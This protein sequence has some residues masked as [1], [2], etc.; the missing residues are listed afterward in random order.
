MEAAVVVLVLVNTVLL[1]WLTLRRTPGAS[2]AEAEVTSG[3]EL[4]APAPAG[5]RPGGSDVLGGIQAA[6][7]FPLATL[8][9][10]SGIAQ[11]MPVPAAT[12]VR[13]LGS[14]SEAS[15]H[16]LVAA[17]A[18][19]ALGSGDLYRMVTRPTGEFLRKPDETF[20]AIG[21]VN[22]KISGH[23]DWAEVS[24]RS[25]QA[26]SALGSLA[27]IAAGAYWQQQVDQK[28]GRLQE[29]L[30][31][32]ASRLNTTLLAELAVSHD[33]LS[34]DETADIEGPYRPSAAVTDGL[35]AARID[36]IELR[37][38]FEKRV[39][40]QDAL[41][42]RDYV[43]RILRTA[44]D[45]NVTDKFQRAAF[46]VTLE[47][48]VLKLKWSHSYGQPPAY[49]EQLATELDDLLGRVDALVGVGR[50]IRSIE[51]RHPAEW[52]RV[53][54]SRRKLDQAAVQAKDGRHAIGD[55][56]SVLSDRLEEVY[57]LRRPAPDETVEVLLGFDGQ[58]MLVMAPS[59]PD[60]DS[61]RSP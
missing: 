27:T 28:L 23:A 22:G 42:H 8:E 3:T 25:V 29:G 50:E 37:Q 2:T 56:V 44:Q 46:G 12:G 9:E 7:R 45:E 58:R 18:L 43:E 52:K 15:S 34:L 60:S 21:R 39:A 26:A 31:G 24:T 1:V 33:A 20:K 47:M 38:H 55:T 61:D 51:S 11:L 10:G 57:S 36:I 14:L 59:T 13:V 5:L 30:D 54:G 19:R 41:E 16:A 4:A 53:L 6:E 17:P 32:V 40:N 48:R 35:R 49:I